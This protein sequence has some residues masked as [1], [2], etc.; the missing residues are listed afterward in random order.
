MPV[1]AASAAVLPV[2]VPCL[3]NFYVAKWSEPMFYLAEPSHLRLQEMCS[4]LWR[5]FHALLFLFKILCL[6]YV[7]WVKQKQCCKVCVLHKSL[8]VKL[9]KNTKSENCCDSEKHS[10][11]PR[12]W[13][14]LSRSIRG[15]LIEVRVAAGVP[16]TP[17][18]GATPGCLGWN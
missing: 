3:D 18:S 14:T 5:L 11:A 16:T 2:Q 9:G 8:E 7:Q 17:M 6:P 15:T 4:C 13:S 12:F 10:L 1:I